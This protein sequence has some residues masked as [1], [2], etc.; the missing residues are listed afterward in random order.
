MTQ[1]CYKKFKEQKESLRLLTGTTNT[2]YR[3]EVREWIILVNVTKLTFNPAFTNHML[4]LACQWFS[5]CCVSHM[6]C[7][8]KTQQTIVM[9]HLAIKLLQYRQQGEK[10]AVK[11][12]LM[13][14]V[15]LPHTGAF[16]CFSSTFHC[17]HWHCVEEYVWK[18]S[19][20]SSEINN[21]E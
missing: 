17:V 19:G 5:Q 8:Y 3:Q 16:K 7:W 18:I 4:S 20:F 11:A 15:M 6:Q 12:L 1:R 2:V 13:V 21:T 10:T 9:K 14:L